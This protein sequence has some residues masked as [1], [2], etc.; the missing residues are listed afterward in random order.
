MILIWNRVDCNCNANGC[1]NFSCA[2]LPWLDGRYIDLWSMDNCIAYLIIRIACLGILSACIRLGVSEPT[3][4]VH[5]QLTPVVDTKSR[6]YLL[7]GIEMMRE[8]S[9]Y[10]F[11][12]G[13]V[14]SRYDA[15]NVVHQP[16]HQ[17][18]C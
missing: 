2:C 5:Y 3:P 7:P 17:Y 16:S 4:Q 10:R 11:K 13:C 15:T 12:C 18:V 6:A 1:L 8:L 14:L 9:R